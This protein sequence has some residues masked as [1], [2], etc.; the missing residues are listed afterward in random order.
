MPRIPPPFPMMRVAAGRRWLLPVSVFAVG[1]LI[2][3]AFWHNLRVHEA[4]AE[5]ARHD[6]VVERLAQQVEERLGKVDFILRG[7]AG[8]FGAQKLV[9]RG[10]FETYVDSLHLHDEL[11]EVVGV[12]LARRV[13][14]KRMPAFEAVLGGLYGRPVRVYPQPDPAARALSFPITFFWPT[15]IVAARVVGFDGYAD[16]IR[17][18]AMDLAL[19]GERL[20]MTAA[21]KLAAFDQGESANAVTLYRLAR[22]PEDASVVSEAPGLVV[23]GLNLNVL[24]NHLFGAMGKAYGLEVEDVTDAAPLRLFYAPLAEA[25]PA[26]P[27]ASRQVSY[28]DRIWRLSVTPLAAGE[29]AG[30]SGALALSGLATSLLAAFLMASVMGRRERAE[31]LALRMTDELRSS[32]RRFEL[33]VSATEEGIWEWRSDQRTLYLSSRCDRLLGYREGTLPRSARGVLRNFTR[34][35]RRDLL[36]A[37]RR[38]TKAP[39]VPLYCVLQ[40]RR[41][42]GSVGWFHV[43]GKAE[44]DAAGRHVRTAGAASDVT[45]LRR[46]QQ[47]VTESHAKL[48]A[49]YRNAYFGMAMVDGESRYLQVNP[50][51]CRIVG[52]SE[53]ELREMSF[54]DLTPKEFLARDTRALVDLSLGVRSPP[55]EKEYIRKDGSRVPVVIATTYV[56]GSDKARWVVVE[57]A[58]ARKASQ[59]AIQEAH[60]TNESLISAMPD[61]LVQLDGQMRIVRYHADDRHSLSMPAESLLGKRVDEALPPEVAERFGR[62]ALRAS[63][64]GEVQRVEYS[65]REGGASRHFEARFRAVRTGGTL[66]VVRDVTDLKEAELA[67]RESE[68]RWQFALDGA[69]DGVWDWNLSTGKVF[70][71]T[72][73]VSMLGYAPEDLDGSI[74]AWSSR[75]H[76]DD[77]PATLEAQ[78]AHLRGETPIFTREFR[79]RCKDGAYKWILARGLVVERDAAGRPLRMIGTQTDID[80]V[81]AREAEILY[82]NTNLASLVE[83]RTKDLMAAKE[84]AEAAN[85][86][87]SIFL[88]N[89]SH[90]IR[91]PMHGVLSYA[92]LGESRIGA[93][94][95][96]KLRSYFNRIRLSGE[97]LLLLL[98]DLLDLSKFEAGRM[99]LNFE[100]TDM[101]TL[102]REVVREFDAL[103]AARHLSVKV[104]RD[105]VEPALFDGDAAR[106]SQ[107]I[108]NLLSNAAKFTPEGRAIHVHIR[109]DSLPEGRRASDLRRLPAV[110]VAVSDEGVGIP[111]EELDAVFEKFVQSSR[112]RTGAGGTGLGL[113]ICREIVEAHRGAISVCNN[114]AGGAEFTVILP[115]SRAAPRSAPSDK[116]REES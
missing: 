64:S 35:S 57:D 112:T 83:A 1:A 93:V 39:E 55:Y 5:Q 2:T 73:W 44:F 69:G 88:A 81:K 53:E 80:Q 51:F 58:T 23:L 70:R 28:G 18:R 66:A 101:D 86:A 113:A 49:L 14:T 25:D 106:V 111:P 65:T 42:D 79:L 77:L 10:E 82:H 115:V 108:R 9:E 30:A 17:R 6:A 15:G 94:S 48:D 72:R 71:S 38:H 97:R 50:E 91:T 68:A 84:A 24:F 52:Y 114:A 96:D 46:A 104:Q 41:I 4:A 100:P 26:A 36:L 87:K 19:Q 75:V 22:A 85:E 105:G 37:L 31:D 74:D 103:L 116:E 29:Q 90:E 54:Y 11:P 109:H 33:A 78:A 89:M 13:E 61:M 76:P 102:V 16:P 43:A 12:G 62:A 107:V 20:A 110:A 95:D 98:N 3:T 59:Q 8:L 7:A 40:V 45:E 21:V 92:S 32:E 27:Q 34:A 63:R 67:L 47:A 56:G 99:I 60:A